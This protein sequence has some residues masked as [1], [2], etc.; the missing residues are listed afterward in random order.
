MTETAST[1]PKPQEPDKPGP[2]DCCESACEPCIWDMYADQVK[3]YKR[4][5]AAWQERNPESAAA[6][7]G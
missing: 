2:Y 6:D 5:L 7:A 1:D 3:A 4:A